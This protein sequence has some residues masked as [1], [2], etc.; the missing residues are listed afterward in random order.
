MAASETVTLHVFAT[1]RD[2]LSLDATFHLFALGFWALTPYSEKPGG[3]VG[4]PGSTLIEP[5]VA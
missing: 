1:Y 2:P 3:G 5:L 4:K